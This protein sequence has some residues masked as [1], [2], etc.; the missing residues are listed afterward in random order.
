VRLVN[1][2]TSGAD[3]DA[4]AVIQHSGNQDPGAPT[5]DLWRDAAG[6]V[7]LLVADPDGLS[8]LNPAGL[9]VSLNLIPVPVFRLRAFM[10]LSTSGPNELHFVS[11][12]PIASFG[13]QLLM[14]A[15]VVAQAGRFAGDQVSLQ[16]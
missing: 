9:R 4:V 14:G 12:Q 5:C 8:D 10:I 7:H 16:P 3:F 15:T 6:F 1:A 11:T 2:S 13:F